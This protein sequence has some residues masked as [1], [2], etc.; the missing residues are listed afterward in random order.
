[1]VTANLT[2][3]SGAAGCAAIDGTRLA[4]IATRAATGINA[5]RVFTGVS[6]SANR[7]VSPGADGWPCRQHTPR[8]P[9]YNRPR[10]RGGPTMGPRYALDEFIHDMTALVAAHPDQATLFDRGSRLIERLVRDPESVPECYRRPAAAGP[11][12]GGGRHLPHPRPRPSGTGAAAGP[13]AHAGPPHP[14]T[15]AMSAALGKP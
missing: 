3:P 2:W 6:S 14:P 10:A 5:R 7:L 15:S 11:P 4:M 12:P 8:G 9:V 13:G 1:M